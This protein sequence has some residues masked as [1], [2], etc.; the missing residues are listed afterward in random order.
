[1]PM[2][3]FDVDYGCEQ[4]RDDIGSDL[5]GLKT[6]RDEAV[7]LLIDLARAFRD[8]RLGS[9]I[10]ATVRNEAGA[11]EFQAALELTIQGHTEPP[12]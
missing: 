1:M 11:S 7:S 2:Y 4:L 12:S 8:P 6:A 5:P 9:R 3:Y 10:T